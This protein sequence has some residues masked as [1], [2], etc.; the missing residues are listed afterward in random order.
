MNW[1]FALEITVNGTGPREA[2]ADAW[3]P[4]TVATRT[5]WRGVRQLGDGR[6]KSMLALEKRPG[7]VVTVS[8][9]QRNRA[10]F[11]TED[12]ARIAGAVVLPGVSRSG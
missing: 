10:A 11:S 9:L 7:T 3:R 6:A 8:V 1:C 5:Y 4:L 2:V 12:L